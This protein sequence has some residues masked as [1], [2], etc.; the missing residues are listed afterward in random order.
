MDGTEGGIKGGMVEPVAEKYSA[1]ESHKL[2]AGSGSQ[3]HHWGLQDLR[4]KC[5]DAKEGRE[6]SSLS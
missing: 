3:H 4:L 1:R 5:V 2:H 6:T